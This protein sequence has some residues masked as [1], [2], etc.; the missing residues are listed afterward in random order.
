MNSNNIDLFDA[1]GIGTREDSYTTLL[2]VLFKREEGREYAKQ[3]F[4]R[5]VESEAPAGPVR[6]E[7]RLRLRQQGG[8]GADIPDLIFAFG[9]HA[10]SILVVEAK[11]KS[12]ESSDQLKRYESEE[13]RRK[14]LK[15]LKLEDREPGKVR[16]HYLYMTLECEKPA[17]SVNFC[18]ISWEPA[19]DSLP[20]D[21]A[22][23]PELFPAYSCLHERLSSY[24]RVRDSTLKCGE[25]S[26]DT[27][28]EDYLNE[29]YGLVDRTNKFHWLTERIAE[30]LPGLQ[31]TFG[32][33]QG[34]GF[35]NPMVQIRGS[36]WQSKKYGED[37]NRLRECFDIH[38]ELQLE[39]QKDVK[40]VLHYETNPYIPGINKISDIPEKQRKEYW[41]LR[42]K[43]AETLNCRKQ[44]LE[45]ADWK[46]TIPPSW[47]HPPP[48]SSNQLAKFSNFGLTRSVGEFREWL[49]RGSKV[50]VSVVDDAGRKNYLW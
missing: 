19:R 10:V 14:I 13:A 20:T 45:T 11:I 3:F 27:V 28:L 9:N 17:K 21:Q 43:F 2:S 29:T 50:M 22:F 35:A 24:Y 44:Q 30:T 5:V 6:V 48:K 41:E 4:Q 49:Q 26:D 34:K 33:A 23:A 18:P 31:P 38:L 25:L 15:A 40:F 37:R 47:K 32:K 1:L 12:G 39:D 42:K 36:S 8:R 16:W 7:S 46:L